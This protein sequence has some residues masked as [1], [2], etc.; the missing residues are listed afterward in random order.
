MCGITGV[1]D[2]AG[3]SPINRE[4]LAAMNASLTHRGP[5]GDGFHFEPG[6]G[7]GHRRLSI[8]DLEGGK[9][10]LYNEDESVVV[11]YNGEIYNF[12]PL[13]EELK[14]KGHSF[15]TH[16]D[17]EV[18]VH[19]WEEWGADCLERFNGMFA[20]ALWDRNRQTLFLARDRLGIKPLYYALLGNGT[21][22]FGSELKALMLNPTVPRDLDPQ[23]VEDYLT[24]GYIPDPRSIYKAV[25]KLE[26]GHHLVLKRGET[27]AA[28][29]R[30]W[31]VPLDDAPTNGLAQQDVEAEL[32]A[33]LKS[34]VDRR[35][36]AD[37]PLGAFLSGGID[38]SAV[39]AM[40]RELDPTGRILT[41]SIGFNEKRYDESKYAQMVADAKTTDHQ[42]ERVEA[43]DFGLLSKLVD[44]Y[45]EPYADSSAIPTYRVCELARK[46][47]TVA[48][49]GDGGDENYI[50]YRRYSLFNMEERMRG[51]F[52]DSFRRSVFGALGHYYPKADWAP[53]V[54]RGKTTFQ[55]LARESQY[56]YQ[57]GVSIFAEENRDWLFSDQLK[58]DLQGYRSRAVFDR[59]LDG[60][61][62]DDPLRMVQYLDFKT[63]LP[64]DI[65]T[66]VDR[67]SMAHSLEVRV[68]FLD[69]TFVS[70]TA[71]LPSSLKLE[72]GVTKSVL[73]KSLQPLLPNDVLYRK[74]MGFAVPLTVWFRDSLREQM[75]KVVTGERL[76]DTGLFSP[77]GLRRITDEHTSGKRNYAAALWALLMFDGFLKRHEAAA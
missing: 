20:F 19:A 59:Y 39:V 66:K 58:R 52:P 44:L 47:V 18:I 11:T 1:V 60:K 3:S 15:R 77:D 63:Y 40:M 29:V 64:G 43:G 34:S 38:S 42:A 24:F 69:H 32:R 48:L 23:A 57:H 16:C 17:T 56:A 70:W 73:K 22:V 67:A 9:Q 45:D 53:R 27:P 72:S 31:D 37:V 71:R 13:V 51:W 55:A 26:P 8:I 21:V 75:V 65:L 68:P 36:I 4:L 74:K 35:L 62:F 33:M 14:A 54:F 30:Y 7:L 2:L 41:C 61:E 50:G 49:S 6:V 5:D 25:R 46:H 12:K 10:P 76:L 28:P